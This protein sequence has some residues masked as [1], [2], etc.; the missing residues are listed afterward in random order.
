MNFLGNVDQTTLDIVATENIT[1]NNSQN[2]NYVILKIITNGLLKNPDIKYDI[3]ISKSSDIDPEIK[4]KIRT[5]EDMRNN[6][7]LN[8]L[9]F[10]NFE[11]NSSG[12]SSNIL[13]IFDKMTYSNSEKKNKFQ[14]SI[15]NDKLLLD[16]SSDLDISYK[17]SDKFEISKKQKISTK[18]LKFKDLSE[19]L[20]IQYSIDNN[21]K[22]YTDI[23]K[24]KALKIGIKIFN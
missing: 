6:Y 21:L 19:N 2:E 11:I 16:N 4:N 20:E 10:K 13:N 23:G 3:D 9:L 12:I 15:T 7:F 22:M 18:K 1:L 17:F 14:L 8:L 5:N 24:D